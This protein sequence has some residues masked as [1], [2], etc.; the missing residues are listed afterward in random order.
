MYIYIYTHDFYT[1]FI[2]TLHIYIHTIMTKCI[3]SI[4][5][6]CVTGST[7]YCFC[8]QI[9]PSR[10]TIEASRIHFMLGFISG[11]PTCQLKKH[12]Q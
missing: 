7:N 2:N 4:N 1:D 9:K 10:S 11:I 3:D 8:F 5:G 12:V 6:F